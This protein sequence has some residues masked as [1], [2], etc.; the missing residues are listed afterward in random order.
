MVEGIECLILGHDPSVRAGAFNNFNMKKLMRGLEI[1]RENRLP[2]IQ[3]VES[4]GADLRG[5]TG[6]DPEAAI[7]REE[8]HFGESGRLF[9]EITELSKLE[10]QPSRSYSDHLLRGC[11]STGMSDYNIFI[12][13]QSK[14]FGGPPLVKMAT[15]EDATDEELG[16]ADMHKNFWSRRLSCAG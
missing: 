11:I 7:K 5:E 14:F 16:G 2:Y 6:E 13:N 10:Y 15:G 1:A 9:Y 12:K 8:D 3:F 4:A